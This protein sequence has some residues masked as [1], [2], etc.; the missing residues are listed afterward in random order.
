MTDG[1][2]RLLQAAV[3]IAAST[4]FAAAVALGIQAEAQCRRI[5]ELQ[6]G[7]AS[8]LTGIRT[9]GARRR[10]TER[11][12]AAGLRPAPRRAGARIPVVH[13]HEGGHGPALLLL[14]GW[15]ASGLVWPAEW[16]RRLEC[17]FRVIRIDNRGSGWSRTAPAPF[18]VADMADDARDV[19]RSCRIDRATVVGLSMGGMIAQEL[20]LRHP[21]CVSRLYL[22]GTAPPIPARVIPHLAPLLVA[23]R[24]PAPGQDMREYFTQQWAN[25][26][27]PDFAAACPDAM[28]ELAEQ[29]LRRVT[30]RQRMWDQLR[31]ISSW[32]GPERLRRLTVS[33]TVVHGNRDPLMPVGNGMRLSRYIPDAEYVELPGVGHL[34]PY[35]AADAVLAMLHASE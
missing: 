4:P 26:T 3:P 14:N 24:K 1:Q 9:G 12:E 15:T 22:L 23:F 10:L 29:T 30:P 31:A 18:T 16:L 28:S 7:I 11:A 5:C 21:Q 19:L 6:I 13:W 25:F 27:G 20:A 8:A 35:E 17:H 33:T 34:V 2:E 32:H